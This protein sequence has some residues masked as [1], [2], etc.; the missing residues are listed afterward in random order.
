MGRTVSAFVSV[1]FVRF[2][3]YSLGHEAQQR[4]MLDT[5]A[6]ARC[7]GE[8]RSQDGTCRIDGGY[9]C[10]KML[11]EDG[12]PLILGDSHKDW[13]E[14]TGQAA[15][16]WDQQIRDNKGDS[17]C[18]CALCTSEVIEQIGCDSMPIQCDA[19]NV[20]DVFGV[21]LPGYRAL[22]EC[23][24]KKCPDSVPKDFKDGSLPLAA[25]Y[26]LRH[27]ALHSLPKSLMTRAGGVIAL[28]M[29]VVLTASIVAF[30]RVFKARHLPHLLSQHDD[31]EEAVGFE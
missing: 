30:R 21:S 28:G 26:L 24:M 16:K 14:I 19:T 5:H 8:N 18:T 27:L 12:Q 17:W 6:L 10:V 13:W 23:L 2:I 20:G 3:G 25:K 1:L 31:D 4:T 22:E 7:P 9:V 15:I 29:S 11:N